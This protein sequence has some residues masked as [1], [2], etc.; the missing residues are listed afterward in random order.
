MDLPPEQRAEVEEFLV[1]I[2][3]QDDVHRIYTALR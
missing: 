3:D 1:A 2:D